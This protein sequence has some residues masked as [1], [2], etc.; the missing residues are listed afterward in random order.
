MSSGQDQGHTKVCCIPPNVDGSEKAGCG[1]AF[2]ALK[3]T[4]CDV[5]QM[6]C[7]ASNVTVYLQS[8]HLLH[9]YMLPVFSPLINCIVH[10]AL[11]KFSP[12]A[13][14]PQLVRIANWYSVRVKK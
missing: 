6:E 4:G 9:G 10:H 3:I 8:D 13:T 1:L 14:L 7:Q 2:V 12:V 5:W 11:L